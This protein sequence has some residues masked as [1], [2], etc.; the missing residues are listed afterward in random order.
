LIFAIVEL[1][2]NDTAEIYAVFEPTTSESK[3]VSSIQPL[4]T[5]IQ[6]EEKSLFIL[7]RAT[8]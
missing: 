1:Q 5:Y 6:K 2:I 4:Q 7:K 3:I 8:F